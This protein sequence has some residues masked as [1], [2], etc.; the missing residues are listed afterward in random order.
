MKVLEQMKELLPVTSRDIG[1][2]WDELVRLMGSLSHPGM[3]ALGE[4]FLE[5]EYFVEAFKR[6]PAAKA[7]T[8]RF[9]AERS[10]A[11]GRRARVPCRG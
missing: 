3:K 4:L 11:H 7:L 5:D 1:E 6:A 10:R 8:T 2:M 9:S